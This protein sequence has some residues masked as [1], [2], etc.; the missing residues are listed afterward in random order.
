MKRKTDAD[1]RKEN[2][3]WYILAIVFIVCGIILG[4]TPLIPGVPY[5]KLQ[6][7]DATILSFDKGYSSAKGPIYY[8][9]ITDNGEKYI[10][11]G[12]YDRAALYDLF[13]EEREATIRFDE[14][15][16]FNR[17]WAEEVVVDGEI[18]VAYNNDA[19]PELVGPIL[20]GFVAVLIGAACLVLLH[21]SVVH[22]RKTQAKRDARIAKK[23]AS[24]NK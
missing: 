3:I 14:G 7:K 23:Y 18:V 12:D 22:N 6:E 20:T 2:K 15:K 19:P 8:Y 5:E 24:S 9:F 13:S 1:I 16:I 4:L 21:L 11:T 10:L 17:K